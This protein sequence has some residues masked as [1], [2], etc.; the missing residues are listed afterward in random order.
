MIRNPAR[1]V[2][3][4]IE[5]GPENQELLDELV[6]L[7]RFVGKHAVVANRS[8]K[9]A[10]GDAQYRHADHFEAGDRKKNQPDDRKNVDQDEVGEDAF[11]AVDGF[12]KGAVPG[13]LWLRIT[14]RAP[15]SR[16]FDKP[17]RRR[18]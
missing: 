7:D 10:E 13:A 18:T 17:Y 14:L 16:A 11:F 8:A 15:A 5:D 6:G 2:A 9:A 3:G 4:A 1:R 12:P